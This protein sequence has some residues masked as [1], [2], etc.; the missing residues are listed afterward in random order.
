MSNKEAIKELNTFKTGAKSELG[1]NAL[2]MAIKAL[3]KQ[4]RISQILDNYDLDTW[5][6]LEM[7]KEAMKK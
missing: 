4:D 2:D 6:V 5:E 3:E 1:E 7:V